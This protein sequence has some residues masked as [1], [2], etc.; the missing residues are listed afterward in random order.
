MEADMSVERPRSGNGQAFK[1]EVWAPGGVRGNDGESAIVN[2]LASALPSKAV[3]QLGTPYAVDD[4]GREYL[5]TYLI[6]NPGS[7]SLPV[8]RSRFPTGCNPLRSS[9]LYNATLC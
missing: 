2:N 1:A 4:G 3:C 9:L 8:R 6:P 5:G 7:Q